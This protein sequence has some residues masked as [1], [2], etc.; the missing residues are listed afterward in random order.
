MN[1]LTAINALATMMQVVMNGI[2]AAAQVSAIIQKAQTEG[3]TTL[4]AEEMAIVKAAD[5]A[6]RAA[7]VAAIEAAT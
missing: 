3:R 5:D 1:T 4:T 6:A 2:A 7:L